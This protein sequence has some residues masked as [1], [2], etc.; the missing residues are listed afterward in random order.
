MIVVG[1]GVGFSF[2][3]LSMAAIHHFGPRQRGSAT[4]T[5][6][7]LRSLGMTVG[8][9]IFGMLQKN[10]FS[11]QMSDLFTGAEMPGLSSQHDANQILSSARS[12]IPADILNWITEALSNSIVHTFSW[13]IL[14]AAAAFLLVFLMPKDRMQITAKSK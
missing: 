13:A 12:S 1:L 2:S 8:A 14:S 10:S 4:S 6:N 7:F 3:V 11:E 5:S 9:S